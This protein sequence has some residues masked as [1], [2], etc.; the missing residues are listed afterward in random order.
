MDLRQVG[1]DDRDWINLAQDRDR[2]RAYVLFLTMVEF[3]ADSIVLLIP[4][5][6][7]TSRATFHMLGFATLALLLWTAAI[8]MPRQAQFPIC[9]SHFPT[10][11]PHLLHNPD[12][13][14]RRMHNMGKREN[15][16]KN[17]PSATLIRYKCQKNSMPDQDLNP[18]RL[19]DRL[20][21]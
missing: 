2:W 9:L 15:P 16:E 1:Y 14:L 3:L 11:L 7:S 5:G 6:L 4:N 21:F 13:F 8:K 17:P 18:D 19:R 12:Y 20:K 10:G